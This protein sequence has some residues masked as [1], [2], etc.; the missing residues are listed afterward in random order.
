MGDYECQ[1]EFLVHKENELLCGINIIILYSYLVIMT[2]WIKFAKIGI[3][4]S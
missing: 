4:R 2:I 3:D 1:S